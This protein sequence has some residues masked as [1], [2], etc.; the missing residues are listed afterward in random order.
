MRKLLVQCAHHILGPFAGDSD[1][2]RWGLELAAGG[3]K[4]AKKRALVAVARKLTV[5]LHKLWVSGEVYVRLKRWSA[6][7]RQFSAGR[8]VLPRAIKSLGY[9][10]RRLCESRL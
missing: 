3:G 9:L 2:R 7:P 6:I 5:L 8:R 10:L 4:N 1:L